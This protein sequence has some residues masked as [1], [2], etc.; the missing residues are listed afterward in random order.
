MIKGGFEEATGL[1]FVTAQVWLFGMDAR[2]DVVFVVDLTLP[3]TSLSTF[4]LK[5]LR[6]VAGRA[7]SAA[8]ADTRA[9]LTLEHEDGGRSGFFLDFHVTDADY[10][11]LGRDVLERTVMV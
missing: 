2:Q 7:T 10:S 5:S 6:S 11:R 1:P 9:I 4:D 8:E 3:R